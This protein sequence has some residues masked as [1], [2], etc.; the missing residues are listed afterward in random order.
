M[1]DLERASREVVGLLYSMAKYRPDALHELSYDDRIRISTVSPVFMTWFNWKDTRKGP[2]YW[3][4]VVTDLEMTGLVGWVIRAYKKW[5][6]W[7]FKFSE[8]KAASMVT[9]YVDFLNE[10]GVGVIDISY[11]ELQQG[12][13]HD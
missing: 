10:A 7:G 5:K 8:D 11:E 12:V 13:K 2:D 3:A 6:Y 4:T 1:K 9:A